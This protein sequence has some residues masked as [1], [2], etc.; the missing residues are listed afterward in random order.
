MKSLNIHINSSTVTTSSSN[1]SITINIVPKITNIK[2]I[3]LTSIEIPLTYYVVNSN[4]DVITFTVSAV[5]YTA[6]LTHGNYTG[7]QFADH[8]EL[9][10]NDL[11]NDFSVTY[12][13][14]TNKLIISKNSGIF[15]IDY[16]STTAKKLIG[17]TGDFTDLA[18]YQST[19]SI[20]LLGTRNIF[21]ISESIT[22]LNIPSYVGIDIKNAI[23]KLPVS[24]FETYSI[25]H[26]L[27]E[28][29]VANYTGQN[30]SISSI[31][32]QLTDDDGNELY[33]NGLYWTA[34]FTIFY[35]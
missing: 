35:E 30:A 15:S 29:I 27:T 1:E 16:E 10:F 24:S 28:C 34:T 19:D 21:L 12:D 9:V 23:Y 31:D 13:D 22:S 5:D 3:V 18:T 7:L 32:I 17:L 4:N 25:A 14:I 11:V 2:K 6:T 8:I 20:D 26:N 33:L